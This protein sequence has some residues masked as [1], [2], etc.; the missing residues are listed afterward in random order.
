MTFQAREQVS[1]DQAEEHLAYTS[2]FFGKLMPQLE[3]HLPEHR[4]LRILDVGAAQGVT[5]IVLSGMGHEVYGVE[6]WAPALEVARDLANRKGVSMTL[7]LGTMEEIPYDDESFDLVIASSVMEHVDDAERS[8]AEAF[9]VLKPG[10]VFWWFSA[11][12]LCPKQSEI[13]LFPLFSWYPDTLKTRIM[14]WAKDHR[15]ELVGHTGTPA[16][17][18]WTPRK[19]RR[20]LRS[21]GFSEVWDRWQL[22]R[23]EEL[24]GFRRRVLLAAKR[25]RLVHRMLDVL[26]EGC[27]YAARK[28][29]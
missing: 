8:M 21:V 23:P 7:E 3:P 6:P 2:E 29:V 19:A 28:P 4:P 9:R 1:V 27:A 17:H 10:G 24:D 14:R 15:P 5:L 13:G 25:N 16:W 12:S 26:V 18:W 22:K 11:S 20:M